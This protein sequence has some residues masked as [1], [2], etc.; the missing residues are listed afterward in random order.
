MKHF[1]E[2]AVA[3]DIELLKFLLNEA[4]SLEEQYSMLAANNYEV[5]REANVAVDTKLLKFLLDKARSLEEQYSILADHNHKMLSHI[6][7]SHASSSENLKRVFLGAVTNYISKEVLDSYLSEESHLSSLDFRTV[8]E[9]FTSYG[10]SVI[11]CLS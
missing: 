11:W 6:I 4:G 5:F 9:T 3:V 1:R 8:L 2:A 10:S 7:E